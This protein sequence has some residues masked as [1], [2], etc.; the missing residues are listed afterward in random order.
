MNLTH[1]ADLAQQ[2]RHDVNRIQLAGPGPD[3]AVV[4]RRGTLRR[5]THQSAVAGGIA[6]VVALT[7]TYGEHLA[8]SA[9]DGLTE[10]GAVAST[11]APP[12]SDRASVTAVIDEV[13]SRHSISHPVTAAG[14]QIGPD[15]AVFGWSKRW[16]VTDTDPKTAVSLSIYPSGFLGPREY[17]CADDPSRSRS[18]SD[19]TLENGVRLI[20]GE[21]SSHSI[22]GDQGQRMSMWTPTALTIHP[23]GR[24][25]VMTVGLLI[26]QGDTVP[27]TDVTYEYS[28][29]INLKQL[30]AVV[31]DPALKTIAHP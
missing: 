6:A 9:S 30:R 7:G 26:E 29:P 4:R 10:D 5:R 16:Q 22:V 8:G 18:C 28:G 24:Q 15:E 2:L 17:P 20:A 3:L 12:V 27:P 25:V 21:S 13:L 11:D 23:D 1:D 14:E 19:V 31:V